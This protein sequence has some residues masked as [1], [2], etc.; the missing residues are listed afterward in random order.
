MLQNMRA[1]NALSRLRTDW[2]TFD[3]ISITN[4]LRVGGKAFFCQNRSKKGE[5]T[6]KPESGTCIKVQPIVWSAHATTKLNI[7]IIHRGV[8]LHICFIRIHIS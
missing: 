5:S 6:L 4:V 8:L 7:F 1:V 2:K 3:H